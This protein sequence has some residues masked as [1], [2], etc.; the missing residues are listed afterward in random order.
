MITEADKLIRETFQIQIEG[1]PPY[2]GR[3]CLSR[4]TLYAIFRKLGFTHGAEIGVRGGKN[5]IELF[6]AIPKLKLLLVDPY[7]AYKTRMSFID[8]YAM[9]EFEAK[10][11]KRLA[12]K[13]TEFIKKPSLEAALQVEDNSLDFVYIDGDHSFD[14]VIQ[15]LIAWVP[16]VRPGGIVSGHDYT[17]VVG[18]SKAVDAY[19]SAHGIYNWYLT[20]GSGTVDEK[21]LHVQELF[22]KTRRHYKLDNCSFFWEKR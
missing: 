18:V 3:D 17:P 19:T 20:D 11:R 1:G 15:D 8:Q 7:V 5:A 13:K 9:S 14:A 4:F 22:G 6:R 21:T 2:V 16:K 10:C 12:G